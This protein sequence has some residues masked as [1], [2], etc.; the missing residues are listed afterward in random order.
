MDLIASDDACP[1]PQLD[2][3]RMMLQVQPPP[4]DKPI[5]I[6]NNSP[7]IQVE[8]NDPIFN[9]M[10]EA[11]DPDSDVVEIRLIVNDIEDPTIFGFDLI[12]DSVSDGYTQGNLMWD[13]DCIEYDFTETK[14]FQLMLLIEDADQC[15]VPGDTVLVDAFVI[16]PPNTDPVVS[17]NLSLPD[18]IDLGTVLNFNAI[19]SDD[20]GDDLFLQFVGGNF[21]PDFYGVQFSEAGG[22]SLVSSEFNWDLVCNASI[23]EDGQEFELL[24]IADDD[25]KCKVKNFDTLRHTL[26][27][28]YPDNAVPEFQNVERFQ[29]VRVNETVQI[30]ISAFDADNDDIALQFDPSFRQPA[31]R[32]IS[33]ATVSGTGSVTSFLEWQPECSLLRF[34]QTTS[35]QDVYFLVTDNAC[36]IP[37]SDTLKLTF[38]VF[39][40]SERRDSFIPPNVF[41]PNNDGLNDTFQ[42]SENL[43][44]NQNLPPDNC[45]NFFEYIVI[46]NRAGVSV[47]KSESRDF[48]WTGGGFP[49]GVYYYLIKY[50]NTEFKGFVHL[51]R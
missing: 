33:F 30:P 8:D 1:L 26:K 27:V 41:T 13:T 11:T 37:K 25:D 40:D 36:P 46:N 29:R 15:L 17:T 48:I 42:L 10:V 50:S 47:F 16:L 18:E 35:L 21:N 28:N 45:D 31:S 14:E 12:I 5:P 2:T 9:R 7:I 34:G 4:N 24:F 23:Y 32:N 22:N 3:V 19:A 6:F 20:D 44:I 38:E 49:S 51:M 39:D 43:D